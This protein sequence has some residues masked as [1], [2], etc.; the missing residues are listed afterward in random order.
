MSWPSVRKF[1]ADLSMPTD[2]G[3]A[4][5]RPTLP[6]EVLGAPGTA[7]PALT[8]QV[9]RTVEVVPTGDRDASAQVVSATESDDVLALFPDEP[10]APVVP[11]AVPVH[12]EAPQELH[13]NGPETE[14]VLK[15]LVSRTGALRRRL[16]E[17]QEFADKLSSEY[18]KIEETSSE[19][20][21]TLT[22]KCLHVEEVSREAAARFNQ[23]YR[24]VDV[25]SREAEQRSATAVETL[26]Q[27]EK[28]LAELTLLHDLAKTEERLAALDQLSGELAEKLRQKAKN[29]TEAIETVLQQLHAAIGVAAIGLVRFGRFTRHWLVVLWGHT[30]IA[31]AALARYVKHWS[32]AF[33]RGATIALAAFSGKVQH[34]LAI[35]EPGASRFMNRLWSHPI[36]QVNPATQA[37]Q[38]AASQ[39]IQPHSESAAS[40]SA[41]ARATR[42]LQVRKFAHVIPFR[43]AVLAGLG[44]L[45]LLG[46]L[47]SRSSGKTDQEDTRL[48]ASHAPPALTALRFD[49]PLTLLPRAK[50]TAMISVEQPTK[51]ASTIVGTAGTTLRSVNLRTQPSKQPVQPPKQ[52]AA[53]RQLVPA[54][55]PVQAQPKQL[56]QGNRFVGTL[57]ITSDPPGAAVLVDRKRV[58]R[59]PIEVSEL[60]SGSHVVWI[61]RSGYLRWT[62][63]VHV[64]AD[65]LTRVSARLEPDSSP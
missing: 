63:A 42:N 53:A 26:K 54:K 50:Q 32:T 60:Q 10:G 9:A 57:E 59:T 47:V 44:I 15:Q 43:G 65:K 8:T 45:A 29:R 14:I 1:E 38:G 11:Y 19:T 51:A 25:V 30:S 34:W 62:A 7:L 3:P 46:F 20:A 6:P 5:L 16:D 41:L 55:P 37:D 4:T 27:I 49:L 22:G 40:R 23:E 36:F 58:G 35:L 13:E 56:V 52:S 64:S 17:L 24:R 31:L 2:S 21:A 18:R 61:E 28:S 33:F 12:A 39:S 48:A